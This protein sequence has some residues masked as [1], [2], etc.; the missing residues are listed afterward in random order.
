MQIKIDQRLQGS[1]ASRLSNM[2]PQSVQGSLNSPAQRQQTTN[3]A[4]Q[5]QK[6]LSAS[7]L[8]QLQTAAQKCQQSPLSSPSKSTHNMDVQSSESPDK[9]KTNQ[10]NFSSQ[11]EENNSS[12][13]IAYLQQIIRKPAETIV[14]HQIQGN[15]A[16]ML[17]T[18]S[19]GEQRLITFDIPNEDCTVQ[20]LLEQVFEI[21]LN[22]I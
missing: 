14:Q 18:L 13:S 4:Q 8:Q 16:K 20:D 3:A 6:M 5:R 12:E 19:N 2:T 10:Q 1:N 21:L 17:V 22:I 7:Q 11:T 15:T 9:T